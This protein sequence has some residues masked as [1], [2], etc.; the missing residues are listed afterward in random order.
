MKFSKVIYF[1]LIGTILATVALLVVFDQSDT[2]DK[3]EVIVP[4]VKEVVDAKPIE[5]KPT[6]KQAS[7][8]VELEV[9]R[10]RPD[11]SLVIAGKGLP[12]SKIEIISFPVAS[13][14]IFVNKIDDEEASESRDTAVNAFAQ[15]P[16]T[17]MT[18]VSLRVFS[19]G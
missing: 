17:S 3:K 1:L 16:P 10:V 19:S 9:I 12:N 11:G 2:E 8:T 4:L 6:R 18:S 13:S 14:P 5:V 15:L 7:E